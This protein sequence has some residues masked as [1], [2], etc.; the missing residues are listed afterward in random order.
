MSNFCH[1]LSSKKVAEYYFKRVVHGPGISAV[2]PQEYADRFVNFIEEK[3]FP[4]TFEQKVE[5]KFD[6]YLGK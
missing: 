1:K 5:E 3:V 6:Q 4:K 2:P